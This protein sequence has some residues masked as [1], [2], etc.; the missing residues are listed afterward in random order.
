MHP[1][2]RLTDADRRFWVLLSRIWG[3][4]RATLHIVQPD[5]VVRWHR[6]GF[7]CY[8]RWKS[9]KRGRAA[10]DPETIQLIRRMC[11]ANP[12][13]GA[14]RIHG[15]LLKLGIEICE[16]TVAKYMI[17]RRGPPSQ[18]WKTFLEIHF[19]ETIALDFF[20]VPTAT[21]KV[22]FVLVILSH[23]RRRILHMNVTEHPSAVWT[24]R[25]LLQSCGIDDQPRYLIRD[26]DAIFGEV[27]Q[28]QVRAL[29]IEEVPIAPKSPWQNPYAERVIGSIRRECLDHVIILDEA[30]LKV[31]LA[32]YVAYFNASHPHQG[33]EQTVPVPASGQSSPTSGS[34]IAVPVLNGLHHDYRRGSCPRGLVR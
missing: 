9:R 23:D 11:K 25:Q 31:V 29:Q 28:R 15:E 24:A 33:L 26:R 16:T 12:L 20:T 13:W 18:A 7:R 14:P 22:L 30:H 19:K 17:K 10:I 8:W 3:C 27:F 32:R 5:T 4:W 6:Q 1:R 34:V 21:F 2:P